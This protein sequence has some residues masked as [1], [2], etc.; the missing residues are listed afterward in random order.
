MTEC[1][2]GGNKAKTVKRFLPV[3]GSRAECALHR[4]A[5][6]LN[7]AQHLWAW[8]VDVQCKKR[9]IDA[10]LTRP[11]WAAVGVGLKGGVGLGKGACVM[12][13][14]FASTSSLP[15]AAEL[16]SQRP[17][18]VNC[19]NSHFRFGAEV[20]GL[21]GK[22]GRQVNHLRKT[23]VISSVLFSSAVI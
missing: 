19:C 1:K 12:E 13:T 16:N 3:I 2:P 8:R 20:V 22:E 17:Q 10:A 7:Y 23:H 18:T 14:D 21:A 4:Q 6:L 15:R 11:A 9:V 5:K